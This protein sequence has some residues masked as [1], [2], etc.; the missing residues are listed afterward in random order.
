ME[1]LSKDLLEALNEVPIVDNSSADTIKC[2]PDVIEGKLITKD[3][4]LELFG[5]VAGGNGSKKPEDFQR[6]KIIEGTGVKCDKT[7]MRINLITKMLKEIAQPNTK[8]DGFDYSEDFDGI[9]VVKDI[10]IYINLKCVVGKGGA[11][12]RSLR[13]VYWF[14]KGQLKVLQSNKDIFFA[15]ILD[16]DEASF[17]MPKFEYLLSLDKFKSV[18]S[19]VYVGDL[20]GYFDWFKAKVEI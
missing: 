5:K 11:Q 13:E 12:T 14:I 2:P 10:K 20:K 7:N 9:Q 1:S 4:R 8:D 18:K 17:C 16:G 15:N 6:Q 3:K 19:N